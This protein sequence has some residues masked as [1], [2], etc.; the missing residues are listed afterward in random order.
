MCLKFP[1]FEAGCAYRLIA[2]KMKYVYCCCPCCRSG[3]YYCCCFVVVFIVAVVVMVGLCLLFLLLSLHLELRGNLF[4][5][6]ISLK[7]ALLGPL[8]HPLQSQN[9][10]LRPSTAIR[11]LLNASLPIQR[12][13]S[14]T[15]IGE[16]SVALT[17]RSREPPPRP[18]LDSIRSSFTPLPEENTA[19]G[20]KA[21]ENVIIHS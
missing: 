18:R 10:L 7:I 4:I 9:Q 12:K 17:T 5:I 15:S 19:R 20:E 16:S 14:S 13:D 3:F 1:E 8:Y 21:G 11:T 2:Y 6:D